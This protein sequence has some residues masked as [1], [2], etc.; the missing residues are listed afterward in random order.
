MSTLD[1][2]LEPEVTTVRRLEVI[3][4]TGRRRRFSEDDKARVVE[5]TLA[6]GAVVSDVARRYG[7]TPQQLFTW[8]REARERAEESRHASQLLQG[9]ALELELETTLQINFPMDNIEPVKKGELGGDVLHRVCGPMGQSCGSI[10]W[11]SKRTKSWSDGWLAKLRADQR[12]ANADMAVLISRAL[13]K[14][15]DNF[16]PIDGIWVTDP[17]FAIPLAIALRQTLIEV[18]NTRQTQN[19]QETKMELVYQ[20]LT[21]PKFRH[22]VQAI[23]EKFSD[24]Q[25]DLDRE[26]RAMTRLWAK[27]EAQIQGVIEFNCRYVWRSARHSRPGTS[28]DRRT[29]SACPGGGN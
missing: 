10:L 12:V 27:R 2:T 21:G 15:I 23:V 19:G 29:R 14:D 11:E 8:R 16:G 3:T 13:P 22:R 7:L 17:R 28:G 26:K 6:P 1:H 18:A 20:Y 24:M 5:E 9:E 25:A 4:G